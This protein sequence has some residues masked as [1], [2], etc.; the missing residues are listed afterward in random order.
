MQLVP[1]EFHGCTCV[2]CVKKELSYYNNF[3]EV[4][5]NE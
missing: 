3:V 1:K 2:V 5:V 4:S